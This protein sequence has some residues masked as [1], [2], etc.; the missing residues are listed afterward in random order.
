[1]QLRSEPLDGKDLNLVVR[2]VGKFG[3]G[4]Y[5]RRWT[6]HRKSLCRMRIVETAGLLAHPKRRF[7]IV[8][9]RR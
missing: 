7:D 5:D 9:V 4:D 6:A 8:A 2:R 1:L 3:A